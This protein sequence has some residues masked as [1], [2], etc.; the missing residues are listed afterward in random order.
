MKTSLIAIIL[1]I[2]S[3]NFFTQDEFTIFCEWFLFIGGLIVF[4]EK[5]KCKHTETIDIG[6]EDRIDIVC[7]K[8]TK[9][10]K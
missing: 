10:I 4:Y 2:I 5:T 8:C 6:D 1:G 3:M 9:W 7:I